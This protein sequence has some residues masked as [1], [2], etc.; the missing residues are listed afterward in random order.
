[1]ASIR[2][3][4]SGQSMTEYILLIALIA[5]ACIAAVKF[6]GRSVKGG[7]E[8]AGEQVRDAVGGK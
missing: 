1:M 2:K 5:L 8:S 6:F 7:F 4:V 3:Q